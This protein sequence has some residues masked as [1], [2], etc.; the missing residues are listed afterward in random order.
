MNPETLESDKALDYQSDTLFYGLRKLFGDDVVD[1]MRLWFMYKKDKLERPENFKELWG[2]AFTCY[3]LLGDDSKVDREDLGSK[4]ANH[5]FDFIIMPMHHTVHSKN[6]ENKPGVHQFLDQV[7]EHYPPSRVAL[8]DGW[9]MQDIDLGISR[10]CV[11]FKRELGDRY[12]NE[13]FPISFSVPLAQVRNSSEKSYD[14]APLVPS[15]NHLDTYIYDDEESYYNDYNRSYFGFTSKKGHMEDL[16]SAWDCL[17]HYEIMAADCVP[18]FTNIE[19]CPRHTLENFPKD[20][21]VEAKK[22]SGVHPGVEGGY[23]PEEDTYIGPSTKIL[24]GELR[25]HIDFDRFDRTSYLDLKHRFRE[26]LLKHLTCEQTATKLTDTM[27]R[28]NAD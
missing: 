13:A 27:I 21:C 15:T 1:I 19:K 23:N 25:G 18:F 24:R 17:R 4:I 10:R 3:G 5:F 9:D 8:I 7:L 6:E 26:H 16:N 14:F 2:K 22:L 12:T 11:Y 20:L 28:I